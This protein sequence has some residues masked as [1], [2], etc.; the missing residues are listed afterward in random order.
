MEADKKININLFKKD[1]YIL[2]NRG[3]KNNSFLVS[4]NLRDKISFFENK[5]FK[6]KDN[7]NKFL[8]SILKL[9]LP[10]IFLEDFSKLKSIS[11][12]LNWPKKPNYILTSYG[13]ENDDLFNSYVM[14]AKKNNTK[15]KLC[16]LQHGYGCIFS[17]ED[18]IA[19][20]LNKK[21]SDI[22]LTWGNNRSG[23]NFLSKTCKIKF[24]IL[25]LINEKKF[26]SFL[27]L[28]VLHYTICLMEI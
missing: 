2:N 28:S 24:Q 17:N 16:I 13:N 21:I 22:F 6:F 26:L 8:F 12:N 11:N 10:R 1:K 9:S 27:I 25:S 7:F 3:N 19:Y 14:Q 18:F 15:T 4:K 23:K 5:N 20:Y